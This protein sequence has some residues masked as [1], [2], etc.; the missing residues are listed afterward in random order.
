MRAPK[1][2][3][4]KSQ[5][6]IPHALVPLSQ[7]VSQSNTSFAQ[8]HSLS[9][10]RQHA[11]PISSRTVSCQRHHSNALSDSFDRKH[12]P[13]MNDDIRLRCPCQ[14]TRDTHTN[15]QRHRKCS[16]QITLSLNNLSQATSTQRRRRRRHYS[17]RHFN[18]NPNKHSILHLQTHNSNLS[19]CLNTRMPLLW[20][21]AKGLRHRLMMDTMVL[22]MLE[23]ETKTERTVW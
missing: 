6:T 3:R 19:K 17:S 14:T 5:Y 2:S 16:S 11:P 18:I 1:V 12:Q 13:W 20:H 4:A 23:V 9:T 10:E 15:N 8:N 7:S 22:G 21:R